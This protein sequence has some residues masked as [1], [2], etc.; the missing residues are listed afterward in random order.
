M[1]SSSINYVLLAILLFVLFVSLVHV[2]K[3]DGFA[4]P[5]PVLP[6]VTPDCQPQRN[7]AGNCTISNPYCNQILPYGGKKKLRKG[8]QV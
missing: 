6:G 5:C 8:R 2:K 3:C 4:D 7:R 1:R